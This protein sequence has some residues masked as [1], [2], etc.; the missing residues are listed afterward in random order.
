MASVSVQKWGTA[1]ACRGQCIHIYRE[2]KSY[3]NPDIDQDKAGRVWV[4]GTAK[5]CQKKHPRN[6]RKNRQKST[7][8]KGKKRP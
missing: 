2:G 4:I 5:E 3:G 8:E 6:H 7:A 1:A